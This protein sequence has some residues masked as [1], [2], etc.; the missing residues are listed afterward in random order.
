MTADV[1]ARLRMMKDE[2]D[3]KRNREFITRDLLGGCSLG[4]PV[5]AGWDRGLDLLS[6]SDRLHRQLNDLNLPPPAPV[7]ASISAMSEVSTVLD[8]R[9]V[10]GAPAE[11]QS[12]CTLEKVR[13]ALE[14]AERESRGRRRGLDGSPSP[15]SSTTSSSVKRRLGEEE[16]G[17]DGS[18]SSDGSA[19]LA[20]GCP[21]CLLYVLISRQ[22]PRCPRCA[23]HVPVPVVPKRIKIDLNSVSP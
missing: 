20:A 19:M 4:S 12:V 21:G 7:A 16:D 23:S 9:V 15:S 3:G 22:N 17:M 14:R 8:L 1:S 11:Y 18:D 2:L 5:P 13:V 6:G 10:G